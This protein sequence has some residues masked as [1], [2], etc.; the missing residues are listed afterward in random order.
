MSFD[1]HVDSFVFVRFLKYSIFSYQIRQMQKYEG[2]IRIP[3][4]LERYYKITNL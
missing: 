2:I 3:V 4:A 1:A